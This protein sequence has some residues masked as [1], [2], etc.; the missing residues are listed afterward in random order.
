M[1]PKTT[2]VEHPSKEKDKREKQNKTL[3]PKGRTPPF[4][5]L[6]CWNAHHFCV[7]LSGFLAHSV[8]VFSVLRRRRGSSDTR[9]ASV[10][11]V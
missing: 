1:R 4:R 6:T 3:K 5:R 11:F 2:D 7:G 8:V 9:A 10:A